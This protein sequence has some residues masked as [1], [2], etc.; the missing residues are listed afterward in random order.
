MESE[1]FGHVRGAFTGAV[2]T[3]DGSF[4]AAN[5]GT[6]FL[7]EIG[8]MP[9]ALQA[10][11]LRALQ[12]RSVSRVGAPSSEPVDIRILSATNRD[13]DI[14]IKEGRFREDLFY[15]LNVIQ[16]QLPALRDRGDD[17]I[18]IGR[19][20]L[21]RAQEELGIGIKGFTPDGEAALR[22]HSWPGNIRELENRIKKA[23]VLATSPLIS[24]TDLGLDDPEFAPLT[25]ADAKENFQRDYINKVL[26]Q[27]AGNR[28]KTAKE[29]GVDPRT[30]FRHL[31]RMEAQNG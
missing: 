22:R 3:K 21:A 31:E 6:L 1:L 24:A 8:E 2:A 25:L 11:I 17:V 30:I 12:E 18:T 15:R 29:L 27:N 9:F 20:F 28:T 7:D 13:L 5:K 10:K 23:T 14:E 16:V 26:A 4:Q 19:Y